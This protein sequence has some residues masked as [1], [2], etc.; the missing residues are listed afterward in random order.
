MKN[1]HCKAVAVYRDQDMH[2]FS[3]QTETRGTHYPYQPGTNKFVNI[4]DFEAT[5]GNGTFVYSSTKCT[6]HI[7]CT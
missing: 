5:G 1:Y 2:P 4:A 3:F 7:I 6:H